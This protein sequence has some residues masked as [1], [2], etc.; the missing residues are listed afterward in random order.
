MAKSV[1]PLPVPG[2][3]FEARYPF[4]RDTYSAFDGEGYSELSTWKPGTRA[5][6][7]GPEDSEMVAD[8][9]GAIILTVVGVFKPGKFPT[10]VFFTRL[11]RDPDGRE[12]GKGKC[13]MTT[14]GNFY[15]L[16]RGYRHRYELISPSVLQSQA[17]E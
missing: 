14:V 7:M 10:R 16:T 9:E 2:A 5:V 6:P 17:A 4:V 11:W 15:A 8:A 13:R 12:F 3:F 1:N